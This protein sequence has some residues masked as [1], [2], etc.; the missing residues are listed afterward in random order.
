MAFWSKKSLD[1]ADDKVGYLKQ[2]GALDLEIV[3]HP[4]DVDGIPDSWKQL[5]SQDLE[6]RLGA[7]VAGWEAV[8][9]SQLSNTLAY[10][11][12]HLT[13]VELLRV[14]QE[15]FL[16]YSLTNT[17]GAPRYY[18]GGNPLRP[19]F[20]ENQ[21][22]RQQWS[23]L[24]AA[25]RSFYEELHDGF[26]EFSSRSSGLDGLRNVLRLADLEW[27]IIDQ[28]G[29]ELQL[30][31]ETSYAF[32]NNGGSGYVVLDLSNAQDEQAT[33]WW[34]NSEPRYGINFWDLIDDWT[35]IGIGG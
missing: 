6:S 14:D 8:L 9:A 23:Q 16:L 31:L 35:V 33:L 18:V 19:N 11:R 30:D 32:F 15:Y 4:A 1:P 27:G 29:L 7:I 17:E 22:L 13:D 10:L 2:F 20:G 25:L 12:A 5:L 21:A 34:A 28:L 3:A 26:Y 24:P